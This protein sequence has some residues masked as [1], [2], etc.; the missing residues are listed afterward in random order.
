M[1]FVLLFSIVMGVTTSV[2]AEELKPFGF[3]PQQGTEPAPPQVC[4]FSNLKLPADHA[5]FAAGAYAGRSTGFQ[6][7]Q[8]GHE[9]TQIDVAVHS[10][11]KPVVLMLGAYEPNIWNIGWSEGTRILAVLASGYHR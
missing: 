11:G 9:A 8:S 1:R 3:S 7:D 6:I 5:V 2:A 4:K 10:P